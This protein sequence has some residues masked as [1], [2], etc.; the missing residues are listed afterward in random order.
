MIPI[1]P[2]PA[3][4]PGYGATVFFIEEA[5]LRPFIGH[6]IYLW[7]THRRRSFWFYPTGVDSRYLYGYVRRKGVWVSVRVRMDRIDNFH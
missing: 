7:L 3:T 4:A 6:Y 5:A 1:N 2:P